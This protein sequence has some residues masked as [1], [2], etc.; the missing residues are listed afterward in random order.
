MYV[1]KLSAPDNIVVLWLLNPYRIIILG[2]NKHNGDDAPWT[3]FWIFFGSSFEV[4][5]I[6]SSW[7]TMKEDEEK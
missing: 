6:W 5:R 3:Q 7:N 2:S 1:D 4:A